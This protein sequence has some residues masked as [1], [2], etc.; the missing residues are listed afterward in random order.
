MLLCWSSNLWGRLWKYTLYLQPRG[1][2]A[3]PEAVPD[4][5]L[6]ACIW[7]VHGPSAHPSGDGRSVA[8]APRAKRGDLGTRVT[9]SVPMPAGSCPAEKHTPQ[10]SSALLQ[11]HHLHGEINVLLEQTSTANPEAG[12]SP[13]LPEG[14]KIPGWGRNEPHCVTSLCKKH[15]R[16]GNG[17]PPVSKP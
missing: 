2:K 17:L 11:P 12:R 7:A 6:G 16:L 5:F 1:A 4:D 10:G 14:R 13:P 3:F 15:P 8:S 9:W